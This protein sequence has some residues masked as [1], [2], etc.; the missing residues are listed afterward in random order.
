VRANVSPPLKRISTLSATLLLALEK[1]LSG[2][3]GLVPELESEPSLE[4]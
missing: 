4:T 2:E 1:V 3:D